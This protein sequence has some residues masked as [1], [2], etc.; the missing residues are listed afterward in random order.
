MQTGTMRGVYPILVTPFDDAGRVDVESLQSL[1]EFQVQAGVQG[2]GVAL[3]SE[4]MKLTE[5]ERVLVTR[6]VVAQ[7]RGR[8]PVVI[9]SGGTCT[10][11]ALHYSRLAEGN[12]ADALML[13]QP[14]NASGA[15]QVREY[16]KA[17]SDAVGIPIF[18]QDTSSSHVSADLARGIAEESEHVTHIKVE[19]SPTPVM[20]AD[21][22][23][24]AGGLLVPFGGAGGNYFIEEMRRGS[25]GTMPGCSNPEA[26]VQVWDL[27]QSGDGR[28]AREAFY[29]GILPINR[30]A[31]QGW[32]A[33]YHVHKEILRQRGV[34]RTANVRGPMVPLDE[35]TRRELQDVIEEFYL[36]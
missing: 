2:I 4:V 28:G 7:A 27:F 3:G 31:A 32:G 1:V 20:V 26:F 36:A 15:A 5:E 6:T 30:L 21:V 23:A 33:F 16:Y 9:N 10:E 22:M 35:A 12:G 29:Q 11:L 24:K 17:V 14:P 18:I 34:I 13:M 25:Q 8:I 19:S